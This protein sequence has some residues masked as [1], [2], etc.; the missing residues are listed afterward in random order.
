MGPGKSTSSY[1]LLRPFFSAAVTDSSPDF[2]LSPFLLQVIEIEPNND[3][4]YYKRFRLYLRQQKF[5]EALADLNS[6]LK[7]KP[8]NE[9]VLA[10][11]AKLQMRMGRCADAEADFIRLHR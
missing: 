2:L 9:M 8:D 5:K 1:L 6:A 10:Q 7:L 4:N 11:R 3:S